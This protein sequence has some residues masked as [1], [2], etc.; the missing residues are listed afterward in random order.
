MS[1]SRSQL[2]EII[3]LSTVVLSLIFVGYQLALDRKV[4]IADQYQYIAQAE[5]DNIRTYLESETFMD[6]VVHDH[7]N[8]DMYP[9]WGDELIPT[10]NTTIRDSI[11]RILN[12]QLRYIAWDNLHFQYQ[13]G[14]LEEDYWEETERRFGMRLRDSRDSAL[15]QRLSLNARREDFRILAQRLLEE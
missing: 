3:G 5:M 1:F 9:F 12:T 2:F 13:Q 7:E 6:M 10:G 8:G 14:L 11:T 4:A 15:I